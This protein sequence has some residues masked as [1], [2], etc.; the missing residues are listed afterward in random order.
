MWG[1]TCS[2]WHLHGHSD[3]PGSLHREQARSHEISDTDNQADIR[4]L[5]R[6]KL[7]NGR[8]PAK[9]IPGKSNRNFL[10]GQ[11][12]WGFEGLLPNVAHGLQ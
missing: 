5:I 6:F 8:N 11:V 4:H 7:P 2:R 12:L 1:R 10:Q 3:K 9:S